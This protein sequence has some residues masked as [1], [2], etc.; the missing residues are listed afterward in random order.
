MELDREQRT[1]NRTLKITN[2]ALQMTANSKRQDSKNEFE[3]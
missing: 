3:V 1:T 2:P